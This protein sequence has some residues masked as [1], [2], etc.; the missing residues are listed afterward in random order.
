[1]SDGE[2]KQLIEGLIS[3]TTTSS[4]RSRALSRLEVMGEADQVVYEQFM[5]N[6]GDNFENSVWK[7]ENDDGIDINYSPAQ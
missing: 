5:E 2:R 7:D 6:A 3:G 1:M 4:Q